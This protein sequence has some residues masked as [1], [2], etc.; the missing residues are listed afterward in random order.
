MYMFI[1]NIIITLYL[2]STHDGS[3]TGV[4]FHGTPRT[5]AT[6]PPFSKRPLQKERIFEANFHLIKEIIAQVSMSSFRE[7]FEE[8]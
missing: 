2:C 8:T 4:Q 5:S 6:Y 1:S 3:W 7:G